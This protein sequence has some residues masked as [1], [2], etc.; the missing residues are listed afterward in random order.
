MAHD[1]KRCPAFLKRDAGRT[2]TSRRFVRTPQTEI[3]KEKPKERQRAERAIYD[4]QLDIDTSDWEF[5]MIS[6]KL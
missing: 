5:D 6:S 1:P 4:K 3:L 2:T